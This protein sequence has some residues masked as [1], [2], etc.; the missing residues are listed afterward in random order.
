M[1]RPRLSMRRIGWPNARRSRRTMSTIGSDKFS[2]KSGASPRRHEGGM[3]TLPPT[4]I[5]DP[6][7]APAIRWGVLA[8]GG[9]ARDWTAALHARTTSRVVAVG[10]RS[11]E[12]AQA[13]ADE[14]GVARV[15]G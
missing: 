13:F 1:V 4:R 14:F 7:D 8:P 11:E 5:A 9:I 2:S 6:Q 12:R 3:P 15:H 10:S